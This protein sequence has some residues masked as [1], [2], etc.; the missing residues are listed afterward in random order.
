MDN[1]LGNYMSSTGF[2]TF[3]NLASVTFAASAPLTNAPDTLETVVA[4]EPRDIIWANAQVDKEL[5]SSR[6][7]TANIFIGLGAILWSIPLAA[8]QAFATAASL[9]KLE[10]CALLFCGKCV[11]I[12]KVGSTSDSL[13]LYI[14]QLEYLGWVGFVQWMGNS[15]VL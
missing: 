3:H 15:R 7:L 5:S 9:G 6:A 1:V 10:F 13:I 4:P 8:I 12:L 14:T 2:V 11:A